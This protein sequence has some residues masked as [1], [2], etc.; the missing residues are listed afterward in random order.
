M[1]KLAILAVLALDFALCGCAVTPPKDS[2]TTTTSG[3]WEAQ[4]IGGTGATSQLNFVTSFNFTSFT[5]EGSQPLSITGFGFFNS[6][7]CFLLGEYQE[8][9]AGSAD[10]NTSTTGQVTGTMI[11]TVTGNN[12]NVLML[13]TN[14]PAHPGGVS[15]TSSGTTTSTGTLSD[16]VVWGTWTLTSPDSSSPCNSQNVGNTFIMCQGTNTCTIP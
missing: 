10:L 13:T 8:S 2:I 7:P 11:Y 5:G 12:G 6:G 14:N 15:G 9:E 1:K 3:N 4:L 16:G